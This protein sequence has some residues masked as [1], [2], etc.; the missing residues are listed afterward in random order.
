M[1]PVPGPMVPARVTAVCVTNQ[2][3]CERLIRA[4]RTVSDIFKTGLTVIHISSPDISAEDAAALEYLFAVSKQH[5]AEMTVL[6][7]KDPARE[8][9]S[10]LKDLKPAHVVTGLPSPGSPVLPRLWKKLAGI[11]FFTVSLEGELQSVSPRPASAGV[12]SVP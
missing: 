1:K 3:Q 10:C 6:Y 5:G 11:N 7:S 9:L 8:L 4:G 12:S 2:Y